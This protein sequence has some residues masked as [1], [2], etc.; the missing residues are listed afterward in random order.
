MAK[1]FTKV[2]VPKLILICSL[3][4]HLLF[5]YAPFVKLNSITVEASMTESKE[6]MNGKVLSILFC[7]V[8]RKS[9]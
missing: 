8:M 3:F 2:I 4:E 1:F 5:N 6:L 9:H 7:H